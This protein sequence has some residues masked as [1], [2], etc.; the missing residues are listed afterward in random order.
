MNFAEL[1]CDG[2]RSDYRL[3]IETVAHAK[4]FPDKSSKASIQRFF[5]DVE[6]EEEI[7]L[8]YSIARG[9]QSLSTP[10]EQMSPVGDK[11]L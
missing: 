4:G 10:K 2:R 5:E 8:V 11:L 9:A 1:H 7:S 6:S 3:A